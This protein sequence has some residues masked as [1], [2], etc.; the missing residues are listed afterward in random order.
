MAETK[1]EG[2]AK[3]VKAKEKRQVKEE[4][5]EVTRPGAEEKGMEEE[6]R[7][8]A[9]EAREPAVEMPQPEAV[10][11]ERPPL[12]RTILTQCMKDPTFRTRVIYHL[13]KKLR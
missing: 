4:A 3:R 8:E 7:E 5:T 9:E 2:K 10:P 11:E 6:P 12:K 13:V 1:K